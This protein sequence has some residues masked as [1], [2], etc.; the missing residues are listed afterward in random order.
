ML[1]RPLTEEEKLLHNQV[2]HHPL[3]TWQW[4]E[5]RQ[6]TGVA[7]ERVGF[8]QAGKLIKSAQ[9]TFHPIPVIGKS[10]GYFPKGEPPDEEV[11]AALTQLGNKHNALF[12]K[13]EPNSPA[14]ASDSDQFA[15]YKSF[16]TAHHCQIGRSLFTKY[17]FLLDLSMTEEELFANLDSKTRYNVNLAH[18]KGVTIVEDS[19]TEGLEQYLKILEETTA[20]QGF[21]AHSPD[22]FRTM[23]ETLRTADPQ[24]NMMRIFHAVYDSTVLTSWIMFIFDGVLYYPY[25]ASRSI[26]RNVMANNLMM[27][28]MI[29]FGKSQGC[30]AFDMWGSLGPNPD[31]RHPWYGFHKFKQGYG[32]QL[33]E[34]LGTYDLVLQ[35]QLYGVYRAAESLRWKLL[36]LKTKIAQFAAKSRH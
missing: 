3:Q 32:G 4:G 33:V 15:T 16:L 17:S 34:S 30:R 27:W 29:K 9:I 2:V 22:Y 1:I 23:W 35:P 12:I 18:R 13:L 31:T 21:Y 24:A 8:F 6:K 5:F 28:E 7:V 36:R 14:P 20:R 19:T 26:H 25:G 11:L 10:A